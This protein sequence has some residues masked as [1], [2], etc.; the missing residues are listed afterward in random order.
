[1]LKHPRILPFVILPIV[2]N[3]VIFY[4]G[5]FYLSENFSLWLQHFDEKI[6][7]WLNFLKTILHFLFNAA[8]AIALAFSF[9]TIANLIG[10]PFYGL[11]SEQVEFISKSDSNDMHLSLSELLKTIPNALLRELQ[12]LSHYLLRAIPL[13]F[14]WI[15]SFLIT[16]LTIIMPFIS[17]LF[18]AKMLAIQYI[19]YA[20]DNHKITFSTLKKDLEN[21]KMASLGFGSMTTVASMIPFFN[22]I[23]VPAAV[24]GGTLFFLDR[25]PKE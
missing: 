16:P 6:P 5:F 21:D 23:A 9:T 22:I 7:S 19:D 10:S 17:F 13:L 8:L 4:F 25:S 18:G 24:C 20:Y 11:M 1:M 2:L 12:K 3:I 14:L 15:L